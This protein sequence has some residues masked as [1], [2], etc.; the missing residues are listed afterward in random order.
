MNGDVE[1]KIQIRIMEEK[2]YDAICKLIHNEL[3]YPNTEDESIYSRLDAILC[4]KDYQTYVAI[5]QDKVVGFVGLCKGIP[6]EFDGR[7]LRVVAIAVD[8]LYQNKGIGKQ[9]MDKAEAYAREENIDLISLNSGLNR[10]DAHAFYEER[11]FDKKG[12]SFRKHI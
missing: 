8:T 3:G 12:Y 2:D 4:H 5:Y 7:Y 10:Y 9:L 1:M 11:G 6:F